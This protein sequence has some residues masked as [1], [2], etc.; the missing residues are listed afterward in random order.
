MTIRTTCQLWKTNYAKGKVKSGDVSITAAHMHIEKNKMD[1]ANTYPASFV[2]L[3]SLQAQVE[4]AQTLSWLSAAVRSPPSSSRM[5]SKIKFESKLQDSSQ[6]HAQFCVTMDPLEPCEADTMCWHHLFKNIVLA[7]QFPIPKREKG[8]GLELSPMLMTTLAGTVMAVEFQGGSIL[9]GLST[10]LIPIEEFESGK[11]IQ[12]HLCVTDSPDGSI[13]LK[14]PKNGAHDIRFLKVQDVGTLLSGKKAYLGWC[15]K[16][17]IL[18]GTAQY[19]YDKVSWSHQSYNFPRS[20]FTGFTLGLASAGMGILGPSGTAGFAISKSLQT[21]YM[22]TEQNLEHRLKFAITRPCLLYDT[23]TRRAWLVPLTCMLLHMMHLRRRELTRPGEP[24]SSTAMPFSRTGGEA[25]EQAYKVLSHNLLAESTTALGSSDEWRATLARLY[26]AL[27]EVLKDANNPKDKAARGNDSHIFGYDLLNIVRAESLFRLSRKKILRPSG[28]WTE[29]AKE[30]SYVI[31][32]SGLGDALVP[33]EGGNKLCQQCS[34]VPC[35]SDFLSAYIPCLA[36]GFEQQGLLE[37]SQ[38]L[39]D[40]TYKGKLYH[41]CK[42][43]GQDGRQGCFDIRLNSCLNVGPK[44]CF[45]KHLKTYDSLTKSVRKVSRKES[46]T[47]DTPSSTGDVIQGDF[48]GAIIFGQKGIWKR[49]Y[50]QGD[51]HAE[52]P[53]EGQSAS[54]HTNR[55]PVL[56]GAEERPA[57]NGTSERPNLNNANET[58][59]LNNATG[60]PDLNNAK[61]RPVVNG[62]NERSNLKNANVGLVV[63]GA[64]VKPP[65]NELKVKPVRNGPKTKPVHNN[66][67]AEPASRGE[68]EGP[69]HRGERERLILNGPIVEP[70]LRGER[71]RPVLNGPNAV[72]KNVVKEPWH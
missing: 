52:K 3:A 70:S 32:C 44:H 33:D 4:I 39:R 34:R 55:R 67:N 41:E 22:E 54:N 57:L 46:T 61:G 60:R 47:A 16:V 21:R 69:S 63:R 27:D 72:R 62:A 38:Q 2:V 36:E 13:D 5:A 31:F 64:E 11:A 6:R 42:D 9:K 37:A 1:R 59:D 26:V 35:N 29:I 17:K 10:A 45:E 28:G 20:E 43:C 56:R 65:P 58:P 48:T 19:K 40:L 18:L 24:S 30:I 12:W 53:T 8:V 51:L 66:P 50:M 14:D 25:G 23:S 71:K 15:Q 7:D 68:R 49:Q